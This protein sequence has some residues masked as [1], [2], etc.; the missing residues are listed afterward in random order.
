MT[1]RPILPPQEIF[2]K[3]DPAS[4]KVELVGSDRAIC[5]VQATAASG[6]VAQKLQYLL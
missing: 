5:F 3:T 1:Y 4:V 2:L 6:N